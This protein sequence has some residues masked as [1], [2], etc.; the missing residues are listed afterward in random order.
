MNRHIH[1]SPRRQ[2]ARLPAGYLV[3]ERNSVVR[4]RT[5]VGMSLEVTERLGHLGGPGK[6][7]GEHFLWDLADGE[8]V[9]L[10]IEGVDDFVEA[11][12]IADERQILAIACQIGLCECPGN[13]VSQFADIAHVNA[14]HTWIKRKGPAKGSV[15]LP[16]RS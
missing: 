2:L 7:V 9:T 10:S 6:H 14:T 13:D 16:L 15:G 8:L 5:Q 3:C 4:I 12:E 11:Q 1:S